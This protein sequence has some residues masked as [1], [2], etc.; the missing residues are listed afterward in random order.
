MAEGQKI[1]GLPATYGGL[2]V[3]SYFHVFPHDHLLNFT[4]YGDMKG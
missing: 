2:R 3:S 1:F 4:L